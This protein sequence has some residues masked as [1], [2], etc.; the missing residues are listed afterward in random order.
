VPKKTID[1][2]S[3][4]MSSTTFLYR[5]AVGSLL[6]LVTHTPPDIQ[7]VVEMQGRAMAAPSA[8]DVVAAEQLMRYLSG[9]RDYGLVLGIG[10]ST[11][12]AY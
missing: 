6:Y 4:D 5:E 1:E 2:A 12:V 9:T 11:L 7:F 10:Y 8:Q 3:T